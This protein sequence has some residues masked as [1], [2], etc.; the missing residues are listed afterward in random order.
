MN[1]ILLITSTLPWPLRRNGG[2]QRT[3]LLRRALRKHGEVD[4]LAIGG[5]QLLDAD[6]TPEALAEHG[7]AGCFVRESTRA[8]EPPPWYAIG[9]LAGL[10]ELLESWRNRFRPEPAAVE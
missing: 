5:S 7:V 6:V 1:R 10:H 9:P 4:I 2:G 3:A 8:I